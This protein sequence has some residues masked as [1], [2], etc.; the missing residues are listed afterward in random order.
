MK[1][2]RVGVLGAGLMGSGIAEVCAKA[3]Y[4]TIVREVSQPCVGQIDGVE[5]AS[6]FRR[7]T[8]EL[9][10]RSRLSIPFSSS[11]SITDASGI[12]PGNNLRISSS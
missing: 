3:G 1:I 2:S 4:R 6:A 7:S 5:A 8:S 10:M 11:C 9:T 12:I